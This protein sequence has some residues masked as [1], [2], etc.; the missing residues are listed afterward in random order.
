MNALAAKP[1]PPT[2]ADVESAYNAA[3]TSL[4][5]KVEQLAAMRLARDFAYAEH[6][7]IKSDRELT[8]ISR[9]RAEPYIDRARRDPRRFATEIE[10]LEVMVD[11]EATAIPSLREQFRAA[12]QL[13]NQIEADRIAAKFQPRQVAAVRK[14]AVALTALSKA[15][16]EEAL[17]H[18]EFEAIAPQPSALLPRLGAPFT[19]CRLDLP[20]TAASAWADRVRSLGVLT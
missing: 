19:Q 2:F 1:D 12:R 20:H 10:A 16:E 8:A 3:E 4:R 18:Q 11:E 15:L 7:A 9:A 13:A 14:I 17:I 6:Q 5:T